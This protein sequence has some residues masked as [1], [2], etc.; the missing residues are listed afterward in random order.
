MMIK[1][2]ER[3]KIPANTFDAERLAEQVRLAI[4]ERSLS[5]FAE[6]TGISKSYISKILNLKL[7]AGSPP[8]RK[9]LI[10]MT[11][12]QTAEPQNG[13]TLSDLF[14]SCGYNTDELDGKQSDFTWGDI[15][16]DIIF[17]KYTEIL[18]MIAPGILMNG[19][20]LNGMGNYM[21]V[22]V[23]KYYFEIRIPDNEQIYIG[24]PAF[25]D[26]KDAFISMYTTV[27]SVLLLMSDR[28]ENIVFYVLTDHKDFY[29]FLA[30]RLKV[31]PDMK[32]AILYTEDHVLILSELKI[33]GMQDVWNPKVVIAPENVTE[34]NKNGSSNRRY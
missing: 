19:L 15:T 31:P 25:G 24:I 34:K 6:V 30:D 4:G 9:M 1:E 5:S 8:S 32:V 11:N 20:A 16:G 22:K 27:L 26:N 2:N 21:S 33:G 7:P 18:P 14:S 17:R 13:V 3:T 23:E 10:K 28:Q 29:Q 12:P